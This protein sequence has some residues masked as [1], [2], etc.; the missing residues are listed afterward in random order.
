[1]QVASVDLV[2]QRL[3]ETFDAAVLKAFIQTMAM[4]KAR[5]ALRHIHQMLRPGGGVYILDFP[6]DD[7][8]LSPTG[9]VLSNLFLLNIYDD[10]QKY[11]IQE[12]RELLGETGFVNF[13]IDDTGVIVAQKS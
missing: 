1:V 12:Y 5:H 3:P 13:E 2:K 6:L 7:S 11:T 4:E 8:R 10:A 9:A